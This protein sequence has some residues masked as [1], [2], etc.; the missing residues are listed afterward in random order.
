MLTREA[1]TQ[2]EGLAYS[3]ELHNNDILIVS[4]DDADITIAQ[5]RMFSPASK[6][7]YQF[8]RTTIVQTPTALVHMVRYGVKDTARVVVETFI[9][10]YRPRGVQIG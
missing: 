6:V 5:W 4:Y 2:I 1:T 10:S 9:G 8:V 3:I 7:A